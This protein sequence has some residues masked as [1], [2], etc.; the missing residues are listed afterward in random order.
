MSRLKKWAWKNWTEGMARRRERL[1]KGGR[2]VG[3]KIGAAKNAMTNR[4]TSEFWMGWS[5]ILMG[6]INS[7]HTG[8]EVLSNIAGA[9]GLEPKMLIYGLLSYAG[10]RVVSKF[11]KTG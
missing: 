3:K 10:G 5:G 11:V 8:S 9:V 4:S 6:L 1:R 7:N 2:K